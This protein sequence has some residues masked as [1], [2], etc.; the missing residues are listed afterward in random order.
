M[1][2]ARYDRVLNPDLVCYLAVG[3]YRDAFSLF[4]D[5]LSPRVIDLIKQK[6]ALGLLP[7]HALS[8]LPPNGFFESVTPVL[9][10]AEANPR[11]SCWSKLREVMSAVGDVEVTTVDSA[12]KP[13]VDLP[14]IVSS[15]IAVKA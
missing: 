12:G 6:V 8:R 14:G 7:N 15:H 11:S 5:T 3:V 2:T 9:V 13:P 1:Q 4:L 10:I